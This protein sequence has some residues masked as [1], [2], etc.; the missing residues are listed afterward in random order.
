MPGPRPL[1]PGPL[2]PSGWRWP[3]CCLTPLIDFLPKATL[4]ATIIVAVLTLVDL[5][6][7]KRALAYSRADFAAVAATIVVT[8][9]LGVEAGRFGRGAAVAA[10]APL[11]HLAPA[12]GRGGAGAGDRAFSQHPPLTVETDP[13]VLTLRVD[14]SLYFAN[15]RYLEDLMLDRVAGDTGC[16]MWS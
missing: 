2:P 1:P 4:A 10:A 12:C 7:L 9:G 16:G 5:S 15:A 8:L 6:I 13:A 11:P 14:E 3:R